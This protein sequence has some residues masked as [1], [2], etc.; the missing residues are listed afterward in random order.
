[1]AIGME[2]EGTLAMKTNS[3][4][5]C[6]AI[7]LLMFGPPAG[8]ADNPPAAGLSHT[9]SFEFRH[10][11]RQT[12][13]PAALSEPAVSGVIPRAVR[14]GNPLQMLN[15]FAPAKFGTAEENVSF[16]PDIPGKW[17]GINFFSISF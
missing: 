1:M 12:H 15:P 2:T 16:D 5:A 17:K 10:H 11:G 4:I 6:V 8:A 7:G 3:L 13:R 14:G 9:G